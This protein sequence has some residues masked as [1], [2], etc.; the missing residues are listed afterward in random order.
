[1]W[2][3]EQSIARAEQQRGRAHLLGWVP[4][5]H[6]AD[7]TELHGLHGEARAEELHG[8][9]QHVQNGST[10]GIVVVGRLRDSQETDVRCFA[11]H[12]L[13]REVEACGGHEGQGAPAIQ[14]GRAAHTKLYHLAAH[15]CGFQR[16]GK[17]ERR[18]STL[19]RSPPSVSP[20]T[21]PTHTRTRTPARS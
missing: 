4:R 7:P 2:L 17:G 16:H 5:S 3:P 9:H 1:M 14:T 15:R 18:V 6:H 13:L 10:F 8:L 11:A 21:S 19:L 20:A 12:R